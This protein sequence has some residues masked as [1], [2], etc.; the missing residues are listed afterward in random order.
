[1]GILRN[2]KECYDVFVSCE[3]PSKMSSTGKDVK[4]EVNGII[5]SLD[6]SQPLPVP[7]P[8]TAC[9]GDCHFHL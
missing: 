8:L 4:N 9:H 7:Y 3:L 1:M 5:F 2:E 6:I